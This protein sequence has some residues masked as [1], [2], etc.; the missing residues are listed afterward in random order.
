M[1]AILYNFIKFINLKFNLQINLLDYFYR[2]EINDY[3]WNTHYFFWTNL[4]Y[5]SGYFFTIIILFYLFL[6]YHP[7]TLVIG[8]VYMYIWILDMYEGNYTI[9]THYYIP[10]NSAGSNNLL[11]NPI[12]KYHP[13]LIFYTTVYFLLMAIQF[14]SNPSPKSAFYKNHLYIRF[15]Y[16]INL[17]SK[18]TYSQYLIYVKI[19]ALFLGSWWALQEGS[20]G[21]WWNWDPS[22]VFG[23]LI[24]LTLVLQS[25][26]RLTPLHYYLYLTT[27]AATAYTNILIY[28]HTQ[29]NFDLISHNFG[30]KINTYLPELY[31]LLA[32]FIISSICILNILIN[33]VRWWTEFILCSWPKNFKYINITAGV[34]QYDSSFFILLSLIST[35]LLFLTFSALFNDFIWKFTSISLFNLP[36]DYNYILTIL[37]FIASIRFFSTNAYVFMAYIW[38]F[39]LK[40]F[41]PLTIF[42]TPQLYYTAVHHWLLIIYAWIIVYLRE[43]SIIFQENFIPPNIYTGEISYCYQST[44]NA[45]LSNLYVSQN[46]IYYTNLFTTDLSPLRIT[47]AQNLNLQTFNSFWLS[48]KFSHKLLSQTWVLNFQTTISDYS[49]PAI[50]VAFI[51]VFIPF[52]YLYARNLIIIF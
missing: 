41:T 42:F 51:A 14:S 48:P 6:A 45:S 26:I 35:Y 19:G 12:N 13:F 25:H 43:L 2:L 34:R 17:I 47:F 9:L 33:F 31:L 29:L 15:S 20:W 4:A 18:S 40:F 30:L 1:Y 27:S 11:L 37:V 28:A 23:L 39:W 32:V 38:L 52:I 24:L 8:A 44:L 22:E 10:Q 3:V 7:R 49:I 50:Y 36:K 5:L 21:G 46:W 16:Y